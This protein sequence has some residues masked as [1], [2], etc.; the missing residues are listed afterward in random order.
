[1]FIYILSLISAVLVP[2]VTV[3][4][5]TPTTIQLCWTSSGSLVESYEVVWKRDT[6]GECSVVKVGKT[7]IT[8]GS[9]CY[10]IT[11]LEE[12]SSYTITVAE[13]NAAGSAVSEPVTGTT[14]EAG[15]GVF[16]V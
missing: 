14:L 6:S 12:D 13:S 1:M 9:T 11:K 5:K 2:V 15:K 10:S 3:V 7:T 4:S 8:D 16:D